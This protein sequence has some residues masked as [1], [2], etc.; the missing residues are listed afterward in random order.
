MARFISPLI[1]VQIWGEQMDWQ[2][3]IRR[4]VEIGGQHGVIT[5]EQINE[6][7]PPSAHSLNPRRSRL[8]WTL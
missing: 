2:A 7:I 4:A 5:F 8:S 3:I 1:E 6:L